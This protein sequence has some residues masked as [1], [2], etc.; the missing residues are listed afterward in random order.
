MDQVMNDQ[1]RGAVRDRYSEIAVTEASCG[2]GSS[3][4]GSGSEHGA[5]TSSQLGY[6]EADLASLPEGAD[7]GLGCGN[8]LALASLRPGEVVLD[9]GSGGGLDCFLAAGR[10][11]ETGRAI[12]IDM[13][14]AMIS[15]A[16]LNAKSGNFR[17]V[18]F[19]LGEIENIPAAD[20]SIDVIISNCVIN[21]SP[22]KPQVFREAFRI[23]RPGGRVAISDV[24]AF[25][26]IPESALKDTALYS[27]CVSGAST[28]AEVKVMLGDAGFTDT[29]V[30]PKFEGSS[31]MNDWA[32]GTDITSYVVSAT[33]EATKPVAQ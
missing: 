19:R 29:R 22:D 15:K 33:I 24:V 18:E 20:N 7:M 14:P 5:R 9:L 21:L 11:G 26:E 12:G 28:A 31:F 23:L 13:T 27:A 2:G 32:P 10:V 17:N 8:P 16:R 3:C 1:I 4:C 25:A 6:T 30:E